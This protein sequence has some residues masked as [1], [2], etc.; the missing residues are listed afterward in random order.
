MA[1]VV[2]AMYRLRPIQKRLYVTSENYENQKVAGE[3]SRSV[4]K[5]I[6]TNLLCRAEERKNNVFNDYFL[7]FRT[8]RIGKH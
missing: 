1:N 3:R 4:A 5:E 7:S 6:V 2:I 8:C